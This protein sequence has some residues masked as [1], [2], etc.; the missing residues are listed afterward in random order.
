MGKTTLYH[1]ISLNVL[2]GSAEQGGWRFGKMRQ[3][4]NDPFTQEAY[5]MIEITKI[6]SDLKDKSDIWL[7][8]V[9]ETCYMQDVQIEN[10]WTSKSGV[11]RAEVAVRLV[12]DSGEL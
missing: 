3:V 11:I 7:R 6:P 2:R 10:V 8:S 12:T 5:Y 1:P 4:K 9:L